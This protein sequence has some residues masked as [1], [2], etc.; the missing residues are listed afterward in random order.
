MK[1]NLLYMTYLRAMALFCVVISHV[2][3]ILFTNQNLQYFSLGPVIQYKNIPILAIIFSFIGKVGLHI[4]LII[5]GFLIVHN[6][7]NYTRWQFL[8]NRLF[9]LIPSYWTALIIC[10]AIQYGAYVYWNHDHNISAYVNQ[11][12]GIWNKFLLYDVFCLKDY[13]MHQYL[14][15]TWTLSIELMFYCIYILLKPLFSRTYIIE[16]IIFYISC[17]LCIIG[18]AYYLEHNT[19]V[20]TSNY[21]IPIFA[22]VLIYFKEE[23][24]ALMFLIIA[25][26]GTILIQYALYGMVYKIQ[27]NL[28][29]ATAS[30]MSYV[31]VLLI[32]QMKYII[33]DTEK[34]KLLTAICIYMKNI[35]YPMYL[36]HFILMII[37]YTFAFERQYIFIYYITIPVLVVISWMIHKYIEKPFINISRRIISTDMNRTNK[38]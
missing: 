29:S 3:F 14:G 5:S 27:L 32:Q 31:I 7:C 2:V 16:L 30:I 22:G 21:F 17:I 25:S 34:F 35:N 12:G 26:Y 23:T 20:L 28:Q 10:F 19:L 4:F 13:N 8:I 33:L 38:P 6:G 9:R 11:I 37:A 1:Q 18:F 24:Q 15:I 36:I